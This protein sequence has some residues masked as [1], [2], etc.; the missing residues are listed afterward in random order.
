[1]KLVTLS[2]TVHFLVIVLLFLIRDDVEN[3]FD[4][5]IK[6]QHGDGMDPP[7]NEHSIK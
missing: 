3:F 7:N 4:R 1:M 6:F 5:N 2:L